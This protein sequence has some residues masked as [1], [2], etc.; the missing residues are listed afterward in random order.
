MLL[1]G[2]KSATGCCARIQHRI[3]G[4]LKYNLPEPVNILF[5][6]A[7]GVFPAFVSSLFFPGVSQFFMVISLGAMF[8]LMRPVQ[9]QLFEFTAME[10]QWFIAV[11]VHL[12]FIVWAGLLVYFGLEIQ[13]GRSV[14][15]MVLVVAVSIWPVYMSKRSYMQKIR[16]VK[17]GITYTFTAVIVIIQQT[18]TLG[19]LF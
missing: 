13:V 6:I 9:D 19:R 18:L 15:A 17:F 11:P 5:R 10:K 7:T 8:L 12:L 16:K 3:N 4:C 2:V 1:P 14:G